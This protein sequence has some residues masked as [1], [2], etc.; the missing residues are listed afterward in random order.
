MVQI[1]APEYAVWVK[2]SARISPSGRFGRSSDSG[3][4]RSTEVLVTGTTQLGM[5]VLGFD[6]ILLGFVLLVIAILVWGWARGDFD[7]RTAH[8]LVGMFLA[9]VPLVGGNVATSAGLTG[10]DLWLARG[11]LAVVGITGLAVALRGYRMDDDTG[12]DDEPSAAA[13]P[14]NVGAE[15]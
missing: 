13:D 10:S 15:N 11:V 2:P 14:E 6:L 4:G 9:F 12:G 3:L 1:S 7:R 8:L 5:A